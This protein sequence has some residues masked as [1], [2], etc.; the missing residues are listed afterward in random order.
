MQVPGLVGI[1][2]LW[3]RNT[4]TIGHRPHRGGGI[5]FW[6]KWHKF[7]EQL[8]M[9]WDRRKR[10]PVRYPGMHI[11]CGNILSTRLELSHL[12]TIWVTFGQRK[13]H[14]FKNLEHLRGWQF[15]GFTA[16]CSSSVLILE[17]IFHIFTHFTNPRPDSW[18]QFMPWM[19]APHQTA[20]SKFLYGRTFCQLRV[21]I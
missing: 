4:L 3:K 1:C 10:R 12:K 8:H 18:L 13:H 2:I 16:P 11:I 7:Y 5:S 14:V 19:F 6:P 17:V 20:K 9:C 15:Y 21:L